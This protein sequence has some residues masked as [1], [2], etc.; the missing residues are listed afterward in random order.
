MRLARRRLTVLASLD[1]AGS[2]SHIERDERGTLA[3]LAAIRRH[4]LRPTVAT[5]DGNMFKTMGDGALVE[6]PSVED[7]VRWGMAFQTAMAARNSGRDDY[8][9]LVRV[10]IALADVFIEGN[11][12]FGA[13]VG[14]VVRLQEAAPP[15][16]LT[17]TH[18]VRWQ[19]VKSLS[20]QFTRR[21]RVELRGSDEPMEIFVW[22]PPGGGADDRVAEASSEAV[23]TAAVAMP[24]FASGAPSIVVL[25]F[26][27]M[28]GSADADAI[29]DGIVEEITATL[30]RVRDFTVIAR[31]S[32]YAY[33]GRAIDVRNVAREL[34]VRYVLE[35]SVRK[36]G[37]RLRVSAQLVDATSGAHIWSESYDGVVD[38]LFDFEDQIAERVA[39]ALHPSIR[40]AEI[41]LAR[42]KRPENLAAYD[43]VLRAMPCLW[44]HRRDDNAEAI[45]LLGDALELDPSYGRAAALA[46]WA[47]AQHVVY[48]WTTDLAAERRAGQRLIEMAA[49][50]VD[51]DPTALTALATAIMLLPADL[52][53]AQHFVDRALAI[54]PNHAWAWTRRGFL[55]VYRGD[56][57]AGIP[58]FER[59]IALSPLDPFSFNCFIGLGL[60]A[61]ASGKP[62]EGAN[63]T[64][65]AMREKVGMTW[66]YRDL[67]VFLAHAG[68]IDGAREALGRLV[69]SRP[70]LTLSIVSESLG[71]MEPPLLARYVEGLRIAG[72][73][74]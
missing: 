3:E 23:P 9:I 74:E 64:R 29:A 12:R 34:G 8:P 46:A 16:G 24:A 22:M 66:A 13:A 38:N 54:D 65:R 43:L 17:I 18:S 15:G 7:A 47:R 25:A 10:G 32:A 14:F 61:F 30:S 27:N 28:T 68:D 63:W 35:G 52:D 5:H 19:L 1:V 4:V 62:A 56:A 58:C 60:A 21:D 48:N 53:R 20:A 51:D 41:A 44:A 6:F 70:N 50:S 72:L 42:R 69:A 36:A 71:F 39:G 40:A 49:E 33:K 45:R 11:D 73:R 2:T 67:A 57:A 37:D 31:N 59:A 26:D 55:D